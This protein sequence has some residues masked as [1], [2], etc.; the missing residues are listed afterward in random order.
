[1]PDKITSFLDY[2]SSYSWRWVIEQLLINGI[3]SKQQIIDIVE[4][5]DG[6]DA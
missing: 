3:V 2:Y 1:M 6:E 4:P 5:E